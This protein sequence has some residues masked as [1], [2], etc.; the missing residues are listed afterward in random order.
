MMGYNDFFNIA[1]PY[2]QRIDKQF[3]DALA[4]YKSRS[5][6]RSKWAEK[7]KTMPLREKRKKC[8]AKFFSS[9]SDWWNDGKR[10]G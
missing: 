7:R 1:D 10:A 9:L 8:Q 2:K 3:N 6:E 4:R 5:A